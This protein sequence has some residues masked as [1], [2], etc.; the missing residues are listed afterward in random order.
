M[1]K[2]N[3]KH[4]FVTYIKTK[5]DKLW[6][7]L[8]DGELTKKY[9]FGTSINK[10][11]VVGGHFEYVGKDKKGN[12][13]VMLEC[14]TLEL[15]PNEKLVHEFHFPGYEESPSRVTYEIE[16]KDG[17]CKLILTHD[18]FDEES[19][20]FDGVFKGWPIILSALKTYLETGELMNY[21]KFV[22]VS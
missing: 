14:K 18:Q 19:K 12:S 22:E 17:L 20:S 13:K 11:W 7:A 6:Q 21:D 2:S 16:E 8:T 1:E 4:V 5:N 9:Y 3:K 15:I 10:E